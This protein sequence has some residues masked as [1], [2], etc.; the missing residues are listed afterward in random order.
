[1]A[2][3]WLV[4]NPTLLLLRIHV[5]EEALESMSKWLLIAMSSGFLGLSFKR[6]E[7]KKEGMF[8]CLEKDCDLYIVKQI[9]HH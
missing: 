7:K 6:R 2:A 5:M 3:D 8:N 1:M 4:S 9:K